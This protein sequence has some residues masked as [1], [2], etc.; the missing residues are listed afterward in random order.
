MPEIERLFLPLGDRVRFHGL[1]EDRQTLGAL[2][3]RADLFVWPAVNEAYG[4]VFLEAQAH[5]CPIVA[6]NYGGV[7]DAMRDGM[8]GLLTPPDNDEAFSDAVR[9][10]LTDGDL[11]HKLS[12]GAQRFIKRERTLIRAAD[13]LR[14]ALLPLIQSG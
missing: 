12:T 13:I 8:T 1:I 11:R 5:G 2:Y 4:M 14:N 3:A 6:G 9:C 7:A 10:L